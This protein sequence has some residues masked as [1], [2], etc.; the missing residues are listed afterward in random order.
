M[1]GVI[2]NPEDNGVPQRTTSTATTPLSGEL[3]NQ[4]ANCFNPM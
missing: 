4:K 3:T 2:N 1:L